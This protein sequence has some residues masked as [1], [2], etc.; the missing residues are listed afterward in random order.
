MRFE[1]ALFRPC[2]SFLDS[3]LKVTYS[4]VNM[5]G[6]YYLSGLAWHLVRLG[7]DVL[8]EALLALGRIPS[9]WDCEPRGQPNQ[10]CRGGPQSAHFCTIEGD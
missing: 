6:L 3:F 9:A 7:V 5:S 8:D 1:F 2:S 4:S 10:G